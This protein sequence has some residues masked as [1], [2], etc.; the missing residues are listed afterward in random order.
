[1]LLLRFFEATFLNY[2]KGHFAVF[3]GKVKTNLRLSYI[4]ATL[5]VNFI[6]M[7]R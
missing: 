5:K 4:V 7:S 6:L 3:L 1:M 2:F